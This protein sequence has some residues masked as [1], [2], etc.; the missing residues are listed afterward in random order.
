MTLDKNV[1]AH[2]SLAEKPTPKSLPVFQS[3]WGFHPVNYEDF[4]ILK[5]IHRRYWE[6]LTRAYRWQ[7]WKRKTRQ[8]KNG[9][10]PYIDPL[11]IDT[12]TK[13]LFSTETKHSRG[14]GIGN[15]THHLLFTRLL[16]NRQTRYSVSDEGEGGYITTG[17]DIIADFN[18]ARMPQESAE[19]VE[20]IDMAPYR[21]LFEKMV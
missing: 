8:H 13:S 18:S 6:R 15:R 17:L 3:R 9:P 1:N 10:E 7:T 5:A 21:E 11:F 4:L 12:A 16:N 19:K 14:P 2:I 20:P